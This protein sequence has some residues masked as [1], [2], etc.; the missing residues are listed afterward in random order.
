[1]HSLSGFI[2]FT[3]KLFLSLKFDTIL[4]AKERKYDEERLVKN[5]YLILKSF[6]IAW[7]MQNEGLEI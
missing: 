3:R 6:W 2:G 1:M 7:G 5:Y 4:G